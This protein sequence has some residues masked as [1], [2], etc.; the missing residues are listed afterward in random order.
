VDIV[1]FACVA[2]RL[3]AGVLSAGTAPANPSA[4]SGWP[5][6]IKHGLAKDREAVAL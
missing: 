5:R 1:A 3:A 2:L 4:G 6:T